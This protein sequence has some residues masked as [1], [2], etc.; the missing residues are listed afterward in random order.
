MAIQAQQ[1]S[2]EMFVDLGYRDATAPRWNQRE[3]KVYHRRLRRGI[4]AR[5]KRDIQRR[6]SAI[7]PAAIGHMKTDGR[8]RKNWLQGTAGDA[9]PAH[10]LRLPVADNLRMILGKLRLP[11][12]L[13]LVRLH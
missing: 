10:T 12:A 3:S 13:I 8:L 6:R 4:T 2:K 7:E 1:Q 9:F 11:L 5:L